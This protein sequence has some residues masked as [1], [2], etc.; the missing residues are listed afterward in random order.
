[1]SPFADAQLLRY[2]KVRK[3]SANSES[4]YYSDL[5]IDPDLLF[6]FSEPSERVMLTGR[7]WVRDVYCKKCDEKV[8]W[9]YEFA[10]EEQ[11]RY[12]ESR[13]I[14]ERALVKERDGFEDTPLAN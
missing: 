8:G 11:Q 10:M 13:V 7:H 6:I 4:L 2:K 9:M 5:E 3:T 1:M 14:L 12:K